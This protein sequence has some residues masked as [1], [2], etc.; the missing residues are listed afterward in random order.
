MRQ[1]FMQNLSDEIIR[2]NHRLKGEV[3]KLS[4]KVSGTS[5]IYLDY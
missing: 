3:T 1:D 2:E 5:C 4:H